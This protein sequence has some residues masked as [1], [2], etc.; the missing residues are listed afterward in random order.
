M[1]S[2][3][4]EIIKLTTERGVNLREYREYLNTKDADDL[5]DILSRK[6]YYASGQADREVERELK[7]MDRAGMFNIGNLSPEHALD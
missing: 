6:R 1:K 3:I 4:D 7:K 2:L 5:R